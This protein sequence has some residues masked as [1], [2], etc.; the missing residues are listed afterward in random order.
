MFLT[1]DEEGIL[2][3]DKGHGPQR[4]MELLVALGRIYDAERLVPIRSAHLSGVSYKTIGDGGLDFLVEMAADS[5][6][7][8]KTTLN[9]AGM[10]MDRWEEMRIDD[11]FASKQKAI[12]DTYGRMGVETNCTCTPYLTG[13]TPKP[14]EN[15]AWAESSALSFVNSVLDARTNR[16]G[17]PGALAAAIIGKTPLY[18]LHLDENRV[19]T[20]V[21]EADVGDE[22]T[23]YSLL[24]HAVGQKLGASVPYFKGIRPGVDGL[25]T[26]AAAM[27]AAGSVA[28]FHV[29]GVTPGAA[30]ARIDGLEK[31][32]FGEEELM[33]AKESITSGEDPDLI[34]VGCPHL[35]ESEVTHLA[36][37]LDGK[38]K[39]A[40]APE[41]WFCTSRTVKTWC[42]KET[43]VLE[44]FGKVLCDTCMIVSPIEAHHQCTAT[45]SAKACTYLPTLCAQKVVCEP[46]E[47]L[48]DR[49][50][51]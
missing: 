18:G 20:V 9:P 51:G 46:Y 16:E 48:M 32:S 15:V 3:G 40:D 8:V 38:R 47:V 41:V 26:M 27:A 44:R 33:R 45:N 39:R 28:M 24:G 22:V 17:G 23:D 31:V 34:A 21:V 2:N 7:R 4:A 50:I 25:K 5:R 30:K 37:M 1:R 36:K 42:P 6:V 10:D 49:V 11:A 13:N 12:I 29:E 14:G 19:P 43:A 35:S